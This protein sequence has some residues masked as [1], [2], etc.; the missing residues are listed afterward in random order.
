M[1]PIGFH[2][3]NSLL[4]SNDESIHMEI[5]DH[6]HVNGKYIMKTF[7]YLPVYI[8]TFFRFMSKKRVYKLNDTALGYFAVG[9]FAVGQFAVRKKRPNR[10]RNDT[11]CLLLKCVTLKHGQLFYL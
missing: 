8:N 6:F 7:H 11:L 5:L 9:H 2:P 4:D 1:K 3:R 10:A